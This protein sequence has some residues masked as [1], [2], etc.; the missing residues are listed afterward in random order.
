MAITSCPSCNK[1]ISDKAQ[2]CPHCG[3]SRA[4][5]SKEDEQRKKK[6]KRFLKMQSI[7]NQSMLAMLLFVVG[8]GYM[9]WEG[10]RPSETEYY[11]AM[12]VSAVGFIWYIVNRVR[13]IIVKKSK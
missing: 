9:Y 6:H 4:G 10:I 11:I 3:F 1:K 2:S 7:N 8:V 12:S 5:M 13:M